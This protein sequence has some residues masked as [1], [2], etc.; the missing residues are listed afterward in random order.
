M[1]IN[2]SGVG[3]GKVG[4]CPP[5]TIKHSHPAYSPSCSVQPSSPAG[6]RL[7]CTVIFFHRMIPEDIGG[8][9]IDRFSTSQGCAERMR[10]L[11][12][13][14]IVGQ[15]EANTNNVTPW[16][17]YPLATASVVS[18]SSHHDPW[19][20]GGKIS[21]SQCHFISILG[22]MQPIVVIWGICFT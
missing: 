20:H 13:L 9:L 5:P 10:A 21:M 3:K 16:Q 11:T 2:I 8:S 14:A 6:S 19:K 15:E 22:G 18:L 7:N 1:L 12:D 4:A 17:T